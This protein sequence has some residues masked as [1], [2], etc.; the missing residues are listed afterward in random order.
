MK[1]LLNNLSEEE[2]NSIREQHEGGMN[3]AI[4]N[5]KTLVE[6]KSGDV[7]PFLAEQKKGGRPWEPKG[8][9]LYLLMDVLKKGGIDFGVVAGI[10]DFIMRDNGAKWSEAYNEVYNHTSLRFQNALNKQ[11]VS[12]EMNEQKR[13]LLPDNLII[14]TLL[15]ASG[16][17]NGTLKLDNRTVKVDGD[18][19]RVMAK[20]IEPK[21]ENDELSK[22][23]VKYDCKKD[24]YYKYW[25]KQ[26]SLESEIF[27]SREAKEAMKNIK[28]YCSGSSAAV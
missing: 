23:I 26:E 2:K 6:T 4:D 18:I 14:N 20:V 8:D 17:V 24:K 9:E 21:P 16:K 27:L 3:V 11:G 10:P 7:K 15:P 25:Y 19:V 12:E 5:F 22:Y 13:L 28:T 1:H